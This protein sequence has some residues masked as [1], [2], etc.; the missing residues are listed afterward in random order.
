MAVSIPVIVDHCQKQT[1][2]SAYDNCELVSVFVGGQNNLVDTCAVWQIEL[3]SGNKVVK[4]WKEIYNDIQQNKT[5][6]KYDN[7]NLT[8]RE[9]GFVYRNLKT[10][11]QYQ[12]FIKSGYYSVVIY[13]NYTC[14]L[15]IN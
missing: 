1:F 10:T 11:E 6:I 3:K 9:Q 7:T 4:T 8:I 2:A 12:T 15:K 14:E 13:Q 5:T